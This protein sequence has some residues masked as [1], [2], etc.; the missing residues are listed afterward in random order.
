MSPIKDFIT[1]MDLIIAGKLR[2]ALDQ[3]FP[4]KD[5][6]APERLEK[7]EQFGKITLDIG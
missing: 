4:L 6:A 3:S 2:S 5:A 1:V 7:G